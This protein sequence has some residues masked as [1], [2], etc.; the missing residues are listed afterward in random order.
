MDLERLATPLQTGTAT[1][2]KTTRSTMIAAA[3]VHIQRL[4]SNEC[5]FDLV[6]DNQGQ[7]GETVGRTLHKRS[8]S[9]ICDLSTE[10]LESTSGKSFRSMNLDSTFA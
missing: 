5:P 8:P 9:R 2:E 10:H 3:T 7:R 6:A 1:D 4:P